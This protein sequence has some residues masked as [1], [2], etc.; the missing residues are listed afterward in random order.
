MKVFLC[1]IVLATIATAIP[2]DNAPDDLHKHSAES[3]ENALSEE[4]AHV[5]EGSKTQTEDA[6]RVKRHFLFSSWPVVYA[7][8]VV[9]ESPV[10]YETPVVKTVI[11]FSLFYFIKKLL[12]FCINKNVKT[13]FY[14][15]Y[16][17]NYYYLYTG[18][19]SCTCKNKNSHQNC[20]TSHYL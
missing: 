12:Y 10:V 2:L 1:V 9:Y 16:L 13:S 4:V 5:V 6:N 17:Y 20:T 14:F 18:N 19:Q 15:V 3:S 7:A 11:Y 8:P